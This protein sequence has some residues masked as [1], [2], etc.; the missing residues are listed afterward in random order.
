M[1]RSPVISFEFFPP[2]EGAAEERFWQTAER[3]NGLAPQFCSVTYGAGGTTRDRTFGIVQGLKA[4]GIE[5]AS[6]LTLVG[7]PRHEVD[8]VA[9]RLTA[10]GIRRIVAL[11]GDMPNMAGG[12]EPH[13]EGYRD[14]AELVARLKRI[15]GF[16][17][18]VGAYPE[19]HPNAASA[20]ADLAHLKRK[21]DAGAERAIT[22]YF[23][24]A[25][26]FLRFRDRARAAGITQPIVAGVLP[27]TNF[28]KLLEFSRKCGANVPAWL[29]ERFAGLDDDPETRALVAAHTAADLCQKLMR[30]GVEDFH[31][32]T[33][34]RANLS[35]AVCRLLGIRP[36]LEEAA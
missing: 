27:V 34:N 33:L 2:P 28:A 6:H 4:R 11:R 24:D 15:G 9:E 18:S 35:Y 17:I 1:T 26:V 25:E 7:A 5:A 36:P 29:H 14:T 16:D 10:A 3:L 23:F 30:E 20:E 32:Y 22:Q 19:T 21:L 8:A 13:P 31:F 12:F